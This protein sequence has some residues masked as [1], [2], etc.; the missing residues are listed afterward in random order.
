M[1]DG[2][3][4]LLA[5]SVVM[6]LASFLAGALP[7]SMTL[8][9]SQLRL[10]STIGMGV[11]V[12]TSLVVIIPEGIEAVYTAGE[13]GRLNTRRGHQSQGRGEVRWVS[14]GV[15]TVLT[16]DPLAIEVLPAFIA[17]RKELQEKTDEP[18]NI[19]PPAAETPPSTSTPET[20]P[21]P[22]AGQE[23]HHKDPPTFYIGLS[24][25]LGFILMFLVDK[26]PRHAQEHIQ[27]P[28]A[29]RHISLSNLSTLSSPASPSDESFLQSLAPTPKQTRSLATTTGL[30]IHA[31][32][33]GIAMG[34]SASSSNTKLGFIVFVAIM[35]H[36][37]PAAFGLTSVLLKQGL[38]KRAARGHLIIFSLAAP[39]GAVST[40]LIVN[41]LGGDHME[42]ERGQW[43][44]GMLL[45]FSAGTFLYV[46]MH[47]MQED[48]S[49]HSH[50]SSNVYAEN[51]SPRKLQKPQMRDT[52]AA[53]G[54]MLIPLLT[55]IGRQY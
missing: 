46:A 26:I 53:V 13:V 10:I 4:M 54:G 36:K 38:S 37:A 42:G 51:T 41:I 40:W 25:I 6:V 14:T 45:L 34:A 44:T 1:L 43:W 30:V 8:S 32:A 24:L 31:A 2:L 9:S 12:G 48:S 20:T 27:Q 19:S 23:D 22:P 29:T 18:A 3:F 55:Q 47:A 15:H 33:D 21:P 7:L 39:F 17:S 5:L 28:P 16:R 35:I 50:P 49:E 52:L 11:L